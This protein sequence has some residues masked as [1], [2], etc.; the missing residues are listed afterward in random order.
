MILAPFHCSGL[1]RSPQL[2]TYGFL[3]L[4]FLMWH[5]P[6]SA[7]VPEDAAWL[8]CCL[9]QGKL[10]TNIR[11]FCELPPRAGM[12]V[13]IKVF[14]LY[15][16]PEVF[17]FKAFYKMLTCLKADLPIPIFPRPMFYHNASTAPLA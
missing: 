7:A 13:V 1:R 10:R 5:P 9:E 6:G 14:V 12:L 8:C 16:P 3:Y 11:Y 4:Q 2:H 17:F 15:F